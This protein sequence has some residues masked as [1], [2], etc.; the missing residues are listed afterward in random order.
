MNTIQGN[1]PI[2]LLTLHSGNL[3]KEENTTEKTDLHTGEMGLLILR[4]FSELFGVYPSLISTDVHKS[5]MNGNRPLEEQKTPEAQELWKQ[6]HSWIRQE[7]ERWKYRCL[8]IDIHGHQ[9]N[10]MFI[11]RGTQNGA[12]FQP[13][14]KWCESWNTHFDDSSYKIYPK[15]WSSKREFKK[16]KG[17]YNT[18]IYTNTIQLEFPLYIRENP[19]DF[20][21]RFVKFLRFAYVGN[22]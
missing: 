11:Y 3:Y 5:F 14:K 4:K 9:F 13:T 1:I 2:I 16:Y 18:K 20:V 22:I 15:S 17:G 10:D 12:S 8:M 21:D 6:I 19:D 7:Q